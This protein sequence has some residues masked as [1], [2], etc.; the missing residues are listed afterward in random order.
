L[1]EVKEGK[2]NVII[3]ADIIINLSK[4]DIKEIVI[5]KIISQ[6]EK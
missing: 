4:V 1:K 5:L 3:I 2:Q 6:N